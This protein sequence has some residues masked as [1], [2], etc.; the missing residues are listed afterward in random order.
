M[1][2]TQSREPKKIFFPDYGS[3]SHRFKSSMLNSKS[4]VFKVEKLQEVSQVDD[5]LGLKMED[6]IDSQDAEWMEV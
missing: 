1:F 2:F 4:I 3:Q 6:K 5:S